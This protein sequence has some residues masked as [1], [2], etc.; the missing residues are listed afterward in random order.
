MTRAWSCGAGVGAPPRACTLFIFRAGDEELGRI[1]RHLSAHTLS[2]LS[3]PSSKDKGRMKL[4]TPSSADKGRI[5]LFIPRS[6]DNGCI[7]RHLSAQR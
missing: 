2:V 6:K 4:F 1:K 3:I 5:N 7:N